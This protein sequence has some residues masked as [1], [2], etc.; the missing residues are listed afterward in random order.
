MVFIG[1]ID[2]SFLHFLPPIPIPL[3]LFLL[4]FLF[5]PTPAAFSPSH[6]LYPNPDSDSH[7]PILIYLSHMNTTLTA[8]CTP[9][10]IPLPYR[11][12]RNIL[13]LFRWKCIRLPRSGMAVFFFFRL[14]LIDVR[15]CVS[16]NL[17]DVLIPVSFYL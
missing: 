7:L 16:V 12:H 11:L 5:S 8:R 13:F 15:D 2:T 17:E 10:R 9:S 4:P 3:H 6:S 1:H 14:M